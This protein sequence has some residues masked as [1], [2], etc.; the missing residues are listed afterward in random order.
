[1]PPSDTPSRARR[2]GA[3]AKSGAKLGLDAWRKQGSHATSVAGQLGEL[4]GV[5]AKLGQMLSYVD[6]M[7]PEELDG[8]YQKSMQHLRQQ[9]PQSDPDTVRARLETEL[10]CKLDEAFAHFEVR[11]FASASLGQVHRARLHDGREVAVKVQHPGVDES[12][13]ADLANGEM[14]RRAF[15]WGSFKR[16][17]TQALFNEMAAKIRDELDYTLEATHQRLF[18]ELHAG[19]PSILVPEPV[20]THC[21]G[22]VLTS[23][24]VDSAPLE[25]ACKA[26]ANARRLWCESLWRCVFR[27]TLVG[28]IFNADPHPGNFG[29][30]PDGRIVCFD[31]GCIQRIEEARRTLSV[32]VHRAALDGQHEAFEAG[33]RELLQTEAGPYEQWAQRYVRRCFEPIFA[34]PFHLDRRYAREV[35]TDLKGV[36][37]GK[38][39]DTAKTDIDLPQGMLLMNRLQF[40]FY[41]LLARLDT[42]ADYAAQERQLLAAL[43]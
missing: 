36:I 29:F 10:S 15:A 35:V 2:L 41:S 4:R 26:P 40:G 25:Q 24:F 19:D 11:P 22:R 1:M 37:T 23:I 32:S 42:P 28:G 43:P 12:I 27:G 30:L 3:L 34:S 5:A 21:T 18:R 38:Q 8:P 13:E 17:D 33:V 16:F 7:L 14:L 39:R 31:F 20:A 9:A 6:G